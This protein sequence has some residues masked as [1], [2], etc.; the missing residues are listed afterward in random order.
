MVTRKFGRQRLY[1]KPILHC[2][3]HI[4]RIFDFAQTVFGDLQLRLRQI[5]Y[6]VSAHHAM[7]FIRS[8]RPPANTT[9]LR[10]MQRQFVPL[11]HRLCPACLPSACF[12]PLGRAGCTCFF[13]YPSLEGGLWLL[14]LFITRRR[15]SIFSA[16]NAAFSARSFSFS[17]NSWAIVLWR[18]PFSAS[19][20][21]ILCF[22]ILIASCCSSM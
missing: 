22:G 18:R 12:S 10:Q 11:V 21:A 5:E 14:L 20:S 15:S 4:S 9:L 6:L 8:N 19:S 3:G 7:Q 2:A 16:H 1:P 13:R 17:D